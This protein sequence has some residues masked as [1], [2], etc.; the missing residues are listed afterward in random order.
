MDPGNGS[1]MLRRELLTGS[2]DRIQLSVKR[3]AVESAI[4]RVG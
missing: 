1:E 2:S 4:V 3:E